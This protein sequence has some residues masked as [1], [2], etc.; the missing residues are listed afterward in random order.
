MLVESCAD[1]TTGHQCLETSAHCGFNHPN[2]DPLEHAVYVNCPSFS[3]IFLVARRLMVTS[4]GLHRF[5][6]GVRASPE[7]PAQR[8]SKELSQLDR[9][10]DLYDS[11]A[12]RIYDAMAGPGDGPMDRESRRC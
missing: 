12:E 5:H 7:A 9:A 10:G 6:G 1:G 11:M 4:Q 2:S 8:R 3:I